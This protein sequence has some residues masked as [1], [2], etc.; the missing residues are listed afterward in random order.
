MG[1]VSGVPSS[2]PVA[3]VRPKLILPETM[4]QA[5]PRFATG[6]WSRP[7]FKRRYGFHVQP[8]A[9]VRVDSATST[10]GGG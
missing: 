3:N 10:M 6:C 8:L 5:N 9:G 4:P 7:W 1:G 2:Y